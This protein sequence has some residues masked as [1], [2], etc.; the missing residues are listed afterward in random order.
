MSAWISGHR[1]LVAVASLGKEEISRAKRLLVWHVTDL[2]GEGFSWGGR[3]SSSNGARTGIKTWGSGRK[4]LAHVGSAKISLRHEL[5]ADLDVYAL[6]AVGNRL[7]R[8][9]AVVND[10]RLEFTASVRQAFGACFYYEIVR[11]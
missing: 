4:L 2:H 7:G 10:N 6:D 1:A 8:I 11:R 3:C 9:D 5:A